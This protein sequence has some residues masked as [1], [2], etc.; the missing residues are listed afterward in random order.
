M[1]KY[2]AAIIGGGPIGGYV[3]KNLADM[4]FNVALFEEHKKIGYPLKCAGIVSH[5]IFKFSDIPPQ[6]KIVQN[7]I[8]GA[9]IHSPSGRILTIGGDKVHAFVIDRPKLDE[10]LVKKAEKSN[11]D[12]FLQSKMVYA[13]RTTKGIVAELKQGNSSSYVEHVECDLL[14]GADGVYSKTREIF[15]FP[16]PTEILHGIGVE[17]TKTCLDPN[18]VEI[19]LGKNIAPGFFAWIIPTSRDGSEARIGL[20]VAEKKQRHPLKKHLSF[21]LKNSFASHFLCDAEIVRHTGG[22]IPLGM[23][24]K[25]VDS[26]IM[27]VG[28]AAAQVKPTS[29]GGIYT[30]LLCATLCSSVAA[31]ALQRKEYSPWSLGRYHR[32][33]MD[34]IGRELSVGMK[35]R[36]LFKNLDDKQIDKYVEMLD[37]EKIRYVIS[38]YGDIDY[39]SKLVFPLLKKKPSLLTFIPSLIKQWLY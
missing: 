6:G 8:R 38:K 10:E 5:R 1:K 2:D 32:L 4:G 7:R 24:K 31:D 26:N 17:V 22:S 33:C 3:A 25:T 39:P 27:L 12:I 37:D 20:C 18:F 29:G 14:I 16:Q 13:R 35:L 15:Q 11:A 28:D 36:T 19:F 30:G 23:L 34:R 21:L 9:H